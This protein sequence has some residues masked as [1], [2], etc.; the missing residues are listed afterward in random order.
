MLRSPCHVKGTW[1]SGGAD[2]SRAAEGRQRLPPALAE[3]RRF[4]YIGETADVEKRVARHNAGIG[5]GF[6]SGRTPVALAYTE[7]LPD[8]PTALAR[9]RQLKRWSRAKKDALI[10]R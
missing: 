7:A 5:C 1:C 4:R 2:C 9:E 10:T 3:S 8:R 6:T